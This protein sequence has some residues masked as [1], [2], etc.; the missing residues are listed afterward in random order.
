MNNKKKIIIP[1]SVTTIGVRAFSN[2]QITNVTI[3]N[4]VTNYSCS[5]F[6]DNNNIIIDNQT[7]VPC[8]P[9]GY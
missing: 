3:P 2:N 5:A 9:L 6:D 4:S 8:I 1:N 7:S